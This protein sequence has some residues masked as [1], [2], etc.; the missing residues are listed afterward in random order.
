MNNANEKRETEN[1]ELSYMKLAIK[2]ARKG[3]GNV[4][5]NPPVG[6]VIVKNGKILSIGYHK[7]YGG[8]HAERN[9]ILKAKAK[10]LDLSGATMYVTLEPCNHYGKTPP[11]TNLIIESGIKKVVI[12]CEDPNQASGN[13][14]EKLKTAGVQVEVGLLKKESERLIKFF[15]KYI[16]KK[17]PYVT[18]KYASTLDGKIADVTGNS[19][20]IT[21]EM[22]KTVHMLRYF[23]MAVLI[24]S[25]TVLNDNPELTVRLYK[26]TSRKKQP[27]RIILDKE[28]KTLD[29]IDSLNVYKPN[30]KVF[31][32]TEKLDKIVRYD[33]IKLINSTKPE[34]ILKILH[35]EGIDSVLIEGGANVFSQFL[36][37]ADEIYGFYGLKI[38]GR[39]KDIFSNLR[40]LIEEPFE[41]SITSIKSAKNKREFMVVMQRCLQE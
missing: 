9:A 32:F 28:G 19:K 38:L 25:E 8:N 20:W 39:G 16:V 18:L 4:N 41:F 1:K 3:L 21:N 17:L 27:I 31:V 33:H 6:A 34:E 24:G 30:S 22:R 12:A 2:A 37:F 29:Y 15:L 11:C 23:H 40:N 5:P 26:T 36:P 10:G 35:K 7:Y 13:G 14:I